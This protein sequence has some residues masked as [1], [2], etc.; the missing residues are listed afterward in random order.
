MRSTARRQPAP[1][2]EWFHYHFAV[3]VTAYV[4]VTFAL[5]FAL[6]SLV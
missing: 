3:T 4:L 5:L 2:S 1:T 6:L